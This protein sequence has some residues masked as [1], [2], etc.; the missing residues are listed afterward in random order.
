MANLKKKRDETLREYS[1]NTRRS[2]RRRK[3]AIFSS[4]LKTF[5]YGLPKNNNG[6]YNSLMRVQP[7]TFDELLSMVNE[8]LKVK[9]DE[10]ATS[11]ITQ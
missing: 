1:Y 9:D 4:L 8:Y 10:V 7:F 6:I 3:I 5:K 2:S 11:G